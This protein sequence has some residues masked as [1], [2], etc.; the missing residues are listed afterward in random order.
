MDSI[1]RTRADFDRSVGI[2]K[3]VIEYNKEGKASKE[4]KALIKETIYILNI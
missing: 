1:L 4:M 3:N 2:G